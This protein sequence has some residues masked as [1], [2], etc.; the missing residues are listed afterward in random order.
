MELGTILVNRYHI[1]NQLSKKAGRRTFLAKDLQSQNLVIV[2]ILRFDADFEWDDHKLFDREA[3]TLKNLN[4]PAI[5]KYLDY[6]DVEEPSTRGFAL[7]Q[8]YID[9]PSLETVVKDGRKFSE[10]E[11]IELADRMLTI[12][13]Y[14]HQ[15]LPPVI[16]RDIKPSNI[17]LGNRSGNSIGDIYLVDFGSVQTAASTD[18]STITIVGSDGYIPLEQFSGQTI[19]A[20]DLYSL[21]MTIV[22][23]LTGIPPTELAKVNGQIKFNAEISSQFYRWLEK[24]TYPFLDKRFDSANLA[25]TALRSEDGSYGSFTA[26]KPANTKVRLSRDREKI[27]I[28]FPDSS[29]FPWPVLIFLLLIFVPFQYWNL[30]VILIFVGSFLIISDQINF[31]RYPNNIILVNRGQK[32]LLAGKCSKNT[33]KIK[34]G[35][36]S[37]NVDCCY[38]KYNPGYKFDKIL[39][40]EG[41]SLQDAEVTVKPELSI[42][43]GLG[44]YSFGDALSQDELLWLGEELSD[45]LGVELKI[46]YPTPQL[47]PPPA[48]G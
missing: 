35:K 23:L 24:M 32:I 11:V 44:Q 43:H 31:K 29:D 42:M 30:F 14:L 2:K 40:I 1:L 39:S 17:L 37:I 48:T 20:S 13:D 25:Q 36:L 27:E 19:T 12:L 22:Y 34:W 9:A 33:Q 16:H 7:V 38:L 5:P 4:H 18:G 3:L 47:Q 45:F 28:V 8:T 46:I 41:T 21:G 26:L 15:Q 10:A 6:F